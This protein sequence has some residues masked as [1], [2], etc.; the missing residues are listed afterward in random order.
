MLA[1]ALAF[2]LVDSPANFFIFLIMRNYVIHFL[3]W[4]RERL[5][6]TLD[7]FSVPKGKV[8][9]CLVQPIR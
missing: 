6:S 9:E 8:F 7:L 2:G 4:L 5:E 3:S 1:S